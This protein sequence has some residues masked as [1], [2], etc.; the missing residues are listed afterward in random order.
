MVLLLGAALTAPGVA[1]GQNYKPDFNCSVDHSK[2]SVATMLCQN[3][4]AAKHELVFD[5]TYYALRQIVG[6]SGWKTLK[7]EA[8]ADDDVFKACVEPET[9]DGILPIADPSCY[10]STIDSLTQ[11]YR[12]RLSGSALEEAS[13]PIN[14]HIALQQKFIDLGYLPAGSVA[15]GVYGEAAREA[16]STWQRVAH[17]PASDGFITDADAA[18]LSVFT[19]QNQSYDRTSVPQRPA[20]TMQ[21]KQQIAAENLKA[22][23][24]VVSNFQ[25]DAFSLQKCGRQVAMENGYTQN[26]NIV[27]LAQ[28][29]CIVYVQKYINDCASSGQ[30]KPQTCMNAYDTVFG[31]ALTTQE[32]LTT[33]KG[34]DTALPQVSDRDVIALE[35]SA[36]EYCR[37]GMETESLTTFACTRR[38]YLDKQLSARGWCW[39]HPCNMDEA[40]ADKSWRLCS[41]L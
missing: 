10:I 31:H 34:D 11:K 14:Q 21:D 24:Y 12:K 22:M 15:D 20:P 9:M 30:F 16:I 41:G 28:A 26:L 38:D 13:R 2:D 29:R 25:Q 18:T 8:I 36:N 1:L 27:Q 4:E 23:E 3:S 39:G 40:E 33:G 37:G 6:K 35:R 17:R 32:A 7:Q 19:A 5:Q